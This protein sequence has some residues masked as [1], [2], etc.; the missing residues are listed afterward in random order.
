M[1]HVPRLPSAKAQVRDGFA[2][3]LQEFDFAAVIDLK[4]IVES[5]LQFLKAPILSVSG[6]R[7]VPPSLASLAYPIM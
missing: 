1:S 7:T 3:L 6:V 5:Y 4:I 2:A